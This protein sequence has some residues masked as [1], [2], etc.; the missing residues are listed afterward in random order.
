MYCNPHV[1][2]AGPDDRPPRVRGASRRQTKEDHT[3]ALILDET[4]SLH[5]TAPEPVA[6]PGDALI[7]VHLAGICGTDLELLKGYW[8]FRGIPGHEFVGQVLEAAES[9]WVGRRVVGEINCSCHDCPTCLA[10]RPR[11]C[12]T[13]TVLGIEGRNG[14][15]A[16]LLTLPLANLHALPEGL[17]P[18]HAVF[19]EPLAACFRILEQVPLATGDRVAVL[20]DGRLG[21]LAAQ[22]LATTGAEVLLVGRH[23]RKL[24]V[25][26]GLGLTTRQSDG[27]LSGLSGRLDVV[28]DAT[29]SPSGLHDAMRLVRPEGTVVMKTTVAGAIPLEGGMVVVPEVRIV[30]SRCGPFEPA[31]AALASGAVRVDPLLSAIYPVTQWDQAFTAAGTSGQWKVLL[32]F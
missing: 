14:A 11:H 17:A 30:G 13:R 21:V 7:R 4:L 10:G 32:R 31:L 26:A 2:G 27:A 20:G 8:K 16:D 24:A 22:V 6:E 5:A 28:V 1:P 18:E 15:F 19:T 3:R 25:A 23:E 9:R 12:P 29:G